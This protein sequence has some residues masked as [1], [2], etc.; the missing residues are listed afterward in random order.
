VETA[1][2]GT[3]AVLIGALL[4]FRGSLAFRAVIAVWGALAGFVLGAGVAAGRR[5][6]PRRISPVT[7]SG[8]GHTNRS[9]CHLIAAG[10]GARRR[11]ERP[12]APR[13][14]APVPVRRE[15]FP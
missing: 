9:T 3:L 4:G 10:S 14:C 1:V 13:C 11:R 8:A 5:C 6:H 2:L 12:Q 15:A 7:G